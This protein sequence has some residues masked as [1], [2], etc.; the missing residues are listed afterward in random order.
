LPRQRGPVAAEAVAQTRRALRH[1]HDLLEDS[2]IPRR[3]I[4]DHCGF[5]RGYLAQLLGGNI[6]LKV[7]HL[8]LILDALGSSPAPF[9]R[10][11]YPRS[12][13]PRQRHPRVVEGLVVSRD[14][15]NVYAYGV[16]SIRE[17]RQR[18]ER[19]EA[20]LWELKP[21]ADED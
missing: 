3:E 13:P 20:A 10:E 16:E 5:S 19:C 17:L 4:E 15:L 9:F 2:G 6:E 21:K 11:L 1:L 8:A 14:N 7:M 18:L 12:P